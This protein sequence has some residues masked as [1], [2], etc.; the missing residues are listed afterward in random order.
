MH[1]ASNG[2][3]GHLGLTVLAGLTTACGLASLWAIF[4]HAPVELQMGI[5]QKIFYFHVPSA[6]SVYVSVV[7]CVSGGVMYL[8]KRGPK[9]DALAVAGAEAALFFCLMVIITGPLWGARAWG[10]FWVWDPRL[11]TFLLAS[12]IYTSVVVLR[13]IGG[14]GEAEKRFAAGL[15]VIGMP[16]LYITH[17]SVQL[18]RGQHPTVI[19]GRG[20]GLHP[21]MVPALVLSF[22]FFT[23]LTALMIW[24]RARAELTRHEL[25]ELEG[26]AAE[27]GILEDA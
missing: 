9:W 8:W 4:V 17:L 22:I 7:V 2:P 24:A 6:Y 12:L 16:V 14:A 26:Q 23:L 5:V 10:T 1:G 21:D 3:R 20:G 15:A 11:T 25:E 19:T 27:L 13:S 18:W